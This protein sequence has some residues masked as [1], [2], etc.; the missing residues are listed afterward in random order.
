[1][2]VQ[3]H[4]CPKIRVTIGA[5]AFW[6]LRMS[7]GLAATDAKADLSSPQMCADSPVSPMRRFSVGPFPLEA[8]NEWRAQRA[9]RMRTNPLI[10]GWQIRGGYI[11]LEVAPTARELGMGRPSQIAPRS[12]TEHHQTRKNPAATP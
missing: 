11:G 3:Q 9:E 12:T 8:S 10:V 1:M 6:E 4:P 7:P 5:A 2:A